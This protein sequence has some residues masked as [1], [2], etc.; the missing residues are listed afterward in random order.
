MKYSIV[1]YAWFKPYVKCQFRL[2]AHRAAEY[3]KFITEGFFA[4]C[5]GHIRKSNLISLSDVGN[6][7]N[8]F[9]RHN[10][11][12]CLRARERIYLKKAVCPSALGSTTNKL[13]F[14]SNNNDDILIYP[15]IC[16]YNAGR[17]IILYD[18]LWT[19]HEIILEICPT[20]L[21]KPINGY[22]TSYLFIFENTI[23]Y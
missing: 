17:G 18:V 16:K 6:F 14:F 3:R 8:E 4:D 22:Y 19:L 11:M 23:F 7:G 13:L 2:S 1:W 5:L 9:L 21:M 10:E 20:N 15:I 12:H